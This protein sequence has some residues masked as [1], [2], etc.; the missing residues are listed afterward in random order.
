MQI[1]ANLYIFVKR[2]SLS[3]EF[4]ADIHQFYYKILIN[5]EIYLILFDIS[6]MI[7]TPTYR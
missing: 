6:S 7:Y 2:S 3:Q 4:V 5:C 1:K